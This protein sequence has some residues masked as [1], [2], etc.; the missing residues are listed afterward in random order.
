MLARTPGLSA[1]PA[2][3]EVGSMQAW[4]GRRSERG[5]MSREA[6]CHAFVPGGH[7]ASSSDRVALA[8]TGTHSAQGSLR[9]AVCY[10]LTA[11]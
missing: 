3:E 7:R 11:R 1:P 9:H 6:D 8:A 2:Q 10:K 4:S 5:R